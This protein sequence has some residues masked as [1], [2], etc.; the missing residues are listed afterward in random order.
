LTGVAFFSVTLEVK[1]LELLREL[2]P[3][4]AAVAML[5]NPTTLNP[6]ILRS[7]QEAAR[8]LGQQLL[9]LEVSEQHLS[10]AV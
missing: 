1:K 6:G 9:A 2:V 3:G 10:S 7:T 4:A 8:S 5:V